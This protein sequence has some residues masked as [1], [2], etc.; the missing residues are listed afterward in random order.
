[1]RLVCPGCG[2]IASAEVWENDAHS[3]QIPPVLLKLPKAVQPYA[4]GYLALFRKPGKVLP[5]R[6]ALKLANELVDL[7][8]SGRVSWERNEE[9]PAPPELWAQALDAVLTREPRGLTNHNYLRHTAWS[10]AATLA[11]KEERLSE[12]AKQHRDYTGPLLKDETAI[13][14]E[15]RAEVAKALKDFTQKF[16]R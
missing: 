6:R 4:L 13:S 8:S 11:G 3:R 9:R 5:W 10:M 1:M 16:G 14:E 12:A 2:T 15:E 7:V